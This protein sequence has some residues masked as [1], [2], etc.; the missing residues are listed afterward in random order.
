VSAL[1]FGAK[2]WFIAPPAYQLLSQKQIRRWAREDL[3][4]SGRTRPRDCLFGSNA[5]AGDGKGG[6]V[7]AGPLPFATC[8]QFG[9]ELVF[10]PCGWGHG[11]LNHRAGVAIATEL[12]DGFLQ[13]QGLQPPGM[14][15][16]SAFAP[17][18]TAALAA[19]AEAL[20]VTAGTAT[21]I[22]PAVPPQRPMWEIQAQLDEAGYGVRKG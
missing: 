8:M 20:E 2:Q 21:D 13:G 17:A 4:P 5:T 22:F 3:L 1:F 7:A 10:V 9:G 15:P 18:V 11:V 19:A 12:R 16:E 14:A 6:S